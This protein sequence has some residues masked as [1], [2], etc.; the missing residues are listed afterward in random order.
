[1][2]SPFGFDFQ[3]DTVK[4]RENA[5]KHKIT[6]ERAAAVFLDRDALSRFDEEHSEKETRWITLGLDRQGVLLVVCHTFQEES[7]SSAKIRLISARGNQGRDAAIQTV[8]P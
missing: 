8:M 7:E 5:K 3:W 6:F 1:M 2:E 4:A